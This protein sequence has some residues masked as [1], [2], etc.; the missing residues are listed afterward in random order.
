L[1]TQKN[2]SA[3]H[4]KV[5]CEKKSGKVSQD[6]VEKTSEIA[7]FKTTGSNFQQVTAV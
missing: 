5:I 7:I 4:R 1:A 6:S 2:S 3:T